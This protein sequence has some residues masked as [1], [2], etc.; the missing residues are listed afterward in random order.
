MNMY[1]GGLNSNLS[2]PYDY[3]Q[4]IL[5][6][7]AAQ[8]QSQ[9]SVVVVPVTCTLVAVILVVFGVAYYIQRGNR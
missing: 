4:F 7:P 8:R 6:Y 3:I 9:L 1:E 5:L 2:F